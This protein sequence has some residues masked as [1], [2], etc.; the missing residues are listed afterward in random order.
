MFSHC[1]EVN[2][3]EVTVDKNAE[4]KITVAMDMHVHRSRSD[5]IRIRSF[6]A[7]KQVCT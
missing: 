3:A 5:E 6:T 1:Q 2:G 7:F 4:A